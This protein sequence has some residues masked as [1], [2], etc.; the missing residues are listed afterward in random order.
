MHHAFVADK[1]KGA[2]LLALNVAASSLQIAV[3]LFCTPAQCC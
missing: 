1:W 2:M 3:Q